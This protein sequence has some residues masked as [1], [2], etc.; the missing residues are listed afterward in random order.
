M[1]AIPVFAVRPR[2]IAVMLATLAV[3]A[4]GHHVYHRV[5]AGD[6]MYSIGWRYGEDYR[7]VAAWNGIATPYLIK[8]GQILRLV[9]PPNYTGRSA[10]V[11]KKAGVA[12]AAVP[13]RSTSRASVKARSWQWPADGSVSLLHDRG[14]RVARGI[15]ISG[16]PGQVVRAAANGR[17]VYTGNSL[18][19][20]GNLV[21]IKHDDEYLS[22]YAFNRDIV[23]NEG[24]EVAAGQKVAE[25]GR[26]NN[27]RTALYFE[28]RRN[29]KSED[30]LRYLPVRR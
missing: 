15:E 14:T 20:Y 25:M 2:H 19:G 22:A 16:Q 6:T 12:P 7:E 9:P 27:N 4:C 3:A 24:E 11:A 29:G 8:E 30:P 1:K 10:P 18:K 26:N 17:V 13:S 5:E 21:I 23:V 28:I